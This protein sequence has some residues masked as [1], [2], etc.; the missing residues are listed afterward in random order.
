ML[1]TN[2]TILLLRAMLYPKKYFA[3]DKAITMA[4]AD[5]K[6]EITE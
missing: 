5:V 2:G 6:P 1:L 3:C 4:E